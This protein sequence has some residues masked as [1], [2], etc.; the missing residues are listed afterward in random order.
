MAI[1][2][3]AYLIVFGFPI[4]IALFFSEKEVKAMFNR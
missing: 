3:A 2:A 4:A 1:A